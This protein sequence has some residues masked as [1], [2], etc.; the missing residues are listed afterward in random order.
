M[1]E[2]IMT[3]PARDTQ[4]PTSD[5]E[6]LIRLTEW[7]LQTLLALLTIEA[8]PGFKADTPLS[9]AERDQAILT[10]RARNLLAD[11]GSDMQINAALL[12]FMEVAA[13]ARH[14]LTIETR[15]DD[16]TLMNWFYMGQ[17]MTVLHNFTG[18]GIHNFRSVRSAE[19]LLA[20]VAT[21]LLV[22]EETQAVGQP[23]TFEKSQ[24]DQL[25]SMARD[26][27]AAA[28]AAGHE[29]DPD[30]YRAFIL[31]DATHIVSR[32]IVTDDNNDV[33]LDDACA[34]LFSDG[35]HWLIQAADD[36]K[37]QILPK[38]SV[39]LMEHIS[40]VIITDTPL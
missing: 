27:K 12:R 29:Y 16:Q 17:D 8:L 1:K 28:F 3:S 18:D 33:S 7:E 21:S 4:N 30:T 31:P 36:G 15:V 6:M 32:L 2:N 40:D 22:L 38:S 26:D 35:H 20:T 13:S 25:R 39:A 19:A 37:M 5:N 11:T 10:L 23:L 14:Y 9:E 24:Y 34:V